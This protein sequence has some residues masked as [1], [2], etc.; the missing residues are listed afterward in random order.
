MK[1]YAHVGSHDLTGALESLP[2]PKAPSGNTVRATGTTDDRPSR[3]NSG[4]ARVTR[5]ASISRSRTT[6]AYDSRDE[7]TT[8][9]KTKKPLRLQEL[10][11]SNEAEGTGLEPAT[12]CPAPHFQCGR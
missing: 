3:S 4:D 9:P 5:K 1:H 10:D 6:L 12:G 8:V 2:A 7:E 11:Q